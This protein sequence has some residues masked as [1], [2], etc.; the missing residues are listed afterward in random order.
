MKLFWIIKSIFIS[1]LRL[2]LLLIVKIIVILHMKV[3]YMGV[4]GSDTFDPYL[5][6]KSKIMFLKLSKQ[7]VNRIETVND[8][9]ENFYTTAIGLTEQIA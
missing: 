5:D 2:Y 6:K 7:Q 9:I 3:E 1:Y 8:I 4:S